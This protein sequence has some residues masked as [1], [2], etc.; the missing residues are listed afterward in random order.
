MNQQDVL[1]MFRQEAESIDQVEESQ[2][3]IINKLAQL[4]AES[5]GRLSKENF[6][7]LVHIGAVMYKEGLGKHRARAE[8]AATMKD[9]LGKQSKP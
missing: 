5:R 3:D 1:N 6:E 8:V 2:G 7:D 4:L 9:S